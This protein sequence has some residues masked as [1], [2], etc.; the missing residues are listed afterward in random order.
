MSGLTVDG[1]R[2]AVAWVTTLPREWLTIAERLVMFAL[3]CDSFEGVTCAP[4]IPLLAQATGMHESSVRDIVAR[5]ARPTDLRPALLERHNQRGRGHRARFT[6]LRPEETHVEA[7]G[8]TGA[9]DVGQGPSNPPAPPAASE[10]EN[11][12]KTAPTPPAAPEVFGPENRGKG[13]GGTGASLS[14]KYFPPALGPEEAGRLARRLEARHP[15]VSDSVPFTKALQDALERGWTP[16]EVEGHLG[17][18]LSPTARVGA[19]VNVIRDLARKP[20]PAECR[21]EEAQREADRGSAPDCKHGTPNGT[22]NAGGLHGPGWRLCPQCRSEPPRA[23]T[24]T[25]DPVES[26]PVTSAIN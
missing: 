23:V 10:P 3:A 19:A 13:A 9:F 26:S 11:R 5:L 4:G 15:G 17:R 12:G 22:Y 1:P 21:V 7:T 6:L 25:P 24:A 16:T 2:P 18:Y 20:S 14:L 8:D